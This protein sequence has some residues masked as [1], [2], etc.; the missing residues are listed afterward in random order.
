MTDTNGTRLEQKMK[1]FN[2]LRLFIVAVIYPLQAQHADV[3]V[4]VHGTLK[5]ADLSFSSIVKIMGNNIANTLYSQTT[6]YIRQDPYF[7]QAQAMQGLGLHPISLNPEH[8]TTAQCMTQLFELQ[9]RI[10]WPQTEHRFYYTFG[11]NGLLNA[12]ERQKEG[13]L[14]YQQLKAELTRLKEMSYEP[15][16][17]IIGYSHGGNVALNLARA[18][19]KENDPEERFFIER[20][21]LLGMPV[22]KATDYLVHHAMFKKIYHIYSTEDAIQT[23]DI[24]GPSQFFSERLFKQR[25]DFLLPDKLVQLRIRVTRKVKGLHKITTEQHIEHEHLTHAKVRRMHK[26]PRHTELWCF[27]WG[28]QWYRELFPLRPLPIVAFIPSLL[29]AVECALPQSTRVTVDY[30]PLHNSAVL[31]PAIKKQAKT[32]PI[33]TQDE[34]KQLYALAESYTPKNFSFEHQQERIEQYLKQARIH[35]KTKRKAQ[36]DERKKRLA[37]RIISVRNVRNRS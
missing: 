33:L 34:I 3:I 7:Y 31:I 8:R 9:C 1:A 27:K 28:A 32:F 21:I 10:H 20:L 22:Q 36:R 29:H 35:L 37:Y 5:P 18:Q 26:D 11:W 14:F 12:Q 15:S 30:V 6:T 13:E 16:V 23:L 2:S 4:F 17:Y 24:F 19:E 25:S